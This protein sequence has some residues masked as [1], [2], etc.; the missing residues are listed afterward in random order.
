MTEYVR[1]PREPTEAMIAA[2]QVYCHADRP[3]RASDIYRAMLAASPQGEGSLADATPIKPSADT[4]ELRERVAS[5]VHGAIRD[6]ED[7]QTPDWKTAKINAVGKAT[8][9]ILALIQS[10]RAG[11]R[12][13]ILSTKFFGDNANGQPIFEGGADGVTNI[14]LHGWTCFGPDEAGQKALAG[15]QLERAG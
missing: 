4:G 9:E 2:A 15:F 7:D 1:V 11:P 3:G 14:T 5:V 12:V 8:D 13:S 6:F 10:E